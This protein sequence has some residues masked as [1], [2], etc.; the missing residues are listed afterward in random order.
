MGNIEPEPEKKKRRRDEN[1]NNEESEPKNKKQKL[2]E[3]RHKC[4]HC[5]ETY[6]QSRNLYRHI[7]HKHTVINNSFNC[8]RT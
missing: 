6:T 4:P 7:K 8:N 3:N 2:Q 1:D 5:S